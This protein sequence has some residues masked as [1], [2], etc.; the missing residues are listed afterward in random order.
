[1]YKYLKSIICRG[2][3]EIWGNR[4][5]K[6]NLSD[7]YEEH[8]WTGYQLFFIKA[9]SF[10]VFLSVSCPDLLE[11]RRGWLQISRVKHIQSISGLKLCGINQLWWGEAERPCIMVSAIHPPTE[12][13][14]C[15]SYVNSWSSCFITVLQTAVENVFWVKLKTSFCCKYLF[16]K[17]LFQIT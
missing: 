11:N 10:Y 5:N 1:M 3:V 9:Q 2:I 17:L 12:A 16:F 4:G 6:Q 8:I 14:F 7:K 15:Q 13:G